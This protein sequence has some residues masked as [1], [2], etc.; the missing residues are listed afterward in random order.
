MRI[1]QNHHQQKDRKYYM[2][3]K[4]QIITNKCECN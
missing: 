4:N 1:Y 3:S 2:I